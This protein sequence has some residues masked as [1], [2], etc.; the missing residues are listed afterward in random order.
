ME[1]G[2]G[3]HMEVPQCFQGHSDAGLF[4]SIQSEVTVTFFFLSHTLTN[5]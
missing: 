4:P 1:G 5:I 2:D 3:S